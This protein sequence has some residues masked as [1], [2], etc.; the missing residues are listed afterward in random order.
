MRCLW[1]QLALLATVQIHAATVA[2]GLTWALVCR[3]REQGF[4]S[5]MIS[6][7]T[8]LSRIQHIAPKA[9]FLSGGPNSVHEGGSPTVPEGFFDYCTTNSIPVMGICYGMQL[10]VQRLGG[11]VQKSATGGEFGSMSME[12]EQGST[13]F[14][15]E[16]QR[17]QTVWMSHGDDATELPDGFTCVATSK[18][19]A[20]VAIEDPQ[21]KFFGLQ[22][23]PEVV[24]SKRGIHTIRHFLK[25]IAGAL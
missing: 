15:E 21:R 6:G 18:Q 22:Y 11:T 4:F 24:H 19:G 7:D 9:V 3:V 23:H 17:E 2:A 20:R 10:L 5:V 1:H 8:D 13:L 16:P 12:V 25:N 14:S